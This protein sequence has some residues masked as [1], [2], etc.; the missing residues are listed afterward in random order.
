MQSVTGPTDRLMY[1]LQ[2][3]DFHARETHEIYLT[4]GHLNGLSNQAARTRDSQ[5]EFN[6]RT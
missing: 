3:E 2:V 4:M 6:S 5:F 1:L